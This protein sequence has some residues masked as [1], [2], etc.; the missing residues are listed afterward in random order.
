GRAGRDEGLL[1]EASGLLAGEMTRREFAGAMAGLAA[2]GW[3]AGQVG[4]LGAGGGG[5]V[6]AGRAG[7]G[8]L[9][10]HALADSAGFSASVDRQRDECRC[11]TLK[12]APRALFEVRV[13]RDARAAADARKAMERLGVNV[14][15]LSEG[16]LIAF[17]SYEA[18][19]A[20]WR[21]LHDDAEWLAARERF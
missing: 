1:G 7:L 18:R 11:C 9:V 14:A 15:R 4:W 6:P 10:G 2:P 5:G 3:G 13:Y 12:R 21:V 16:L 20:A 17:D 19:E 8:P